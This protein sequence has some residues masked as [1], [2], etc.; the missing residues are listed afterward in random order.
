[1]ST[2]LNDTRYAIRGLARSRTFTIVAILALAIGVG[3]NTAIFSVVNTVL[4]RALPY[5]Q[6]DRIVM[7]WE[8]NLSKSVSPHNVVS[9]ANF[10]A[11]QDDAKSFRAMGAW[12]DQQGAVSGGGRDPV[13]VPIRHASAATFA[14][15]GVRPVLGRTYTRDEDVRNGPRLAVIS[16]DFWQQY[17]GGRADVI[18]SPFRLDG[19]SF[20]VLGVMPKDFRFFD[21]VKVW[22]PMQFDDSARTFGG[23][24]LHVAARLEPGVTVEQANSEIQ[25]IAERRARDVP[26]LD[27]NWT[28]N[29]QP[30]REALVGDVRTGLL[31]LSGAVGFLLLIACVN[32]ANLMLAR[33]SNRQKEFA[34]RASLGAT[35]ARLVRQLLTEGVVLS[36]VAS[37]IGIGLALFGI[38]A[39]VALVPSTFPIPSI[40]DVAIDWRVLAFTLVIAVLTGIAFGLSPARTV[41][42]VELQDSL[43]EGGRTGTGAGRAS[44]RVRGALVIAEMSLA[45]VLL[46]G[47]G[48]MMRSFSQ[49]NSVNLGIEPD[50]ALMAEIALPNATYSNDTTRVA[51]F[52]E[53]ESRIAKLPGVKSVGS[54][55]YLPLTGLRSATG[56]AVAGRPR[57]PKGQEPTGDMRAVTPGYFRAIGTT[58]KAGRSFTDADIAGRPEVAIIG[59]TLAR[60]YWPDQNPVGQY[61]D[62]EW[63]GDTHVQIV[64]VASDVHDAGAGK[65]PYMEIYR[66]LAQFPYSGMTIVVRASG[67]PALLEAPL[68]N[69]VRSVDPNQPI[70]KLETMDALVSE[71]LANG[72]LSMMLFGMFGAVGLLL[73]CIGIYGVTSYGVLQ[74]TREFGIR[75]AL[76]AQPSDVRN[77]VVQGGAKLTL[78]G[79]GI[80]LVGAIALTRLMRSLLFGVT[81]TDPMTYAGSVAVL[82]LV[83]VVASYVPARRATQVDPVIALRNE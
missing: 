69:V 28:A 6:P 26:Q 23:R 46:A 15:L 71:S 51:F 11:W 53:V 72:R 75:M 66:P 55:S 41:S 27:A 13:S 81:P 30:L 64:G 36:V 10:L 32:V 40:S 59:E 44:A 39:I 20:T 56:F 76:G 43:R 47:A 9:P 80:G 18:G 60:T 29:A 73:A 5:P 3:A 83:S 37:L 49:L 68:R 79:I 54:I 52:N 1:M 61:I 34:I 25:T 67:D 57:P 63:D 42:Q 50:H 77:L 22:A 35:P 24:Y 65:D 82:A 8:H 21:P 4:L 7:L 14:V 58:I 62:Y 33:A 2:L 48:L 12:F 31:V 17:F 74:R 78:I 38:R 16:Y 45:I 70:A 19:E